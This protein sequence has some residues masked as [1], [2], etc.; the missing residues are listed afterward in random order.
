[1]SIISF[2]SPIIS[3]NSKELTFRAT[4]FFDSY[5][6]F[7]GRKY[8]VISK[9]A[10]NR[11]QVEETHISSSRLLNLF[12]VATMITGFIPLI[13]LI[14]KLAAR[15]RNQFYL[16]SS[17]SISS[18][19][20][21]SKSNKGASKRKISSHLPAK[22]EKV[23]E[24]ARAFGVY[25]RAAQERLGAGRIQQ[26]N[27]DFTLSEAQRA[28][29]A[30]ARQHFYDFRQPPGMKI[31]RGGTHL[32]CQIDSVP[33]F[34]FKVSP[35]DVD[36]DHYDQYVQRSQEARE[37]IMRESLFLLDVPASQVIEVDGHRM[38]MQ[39]RAQIEQGSFE[40]QR[41]L[42]QALLADNDL[43]PYMKELYRQ[44]AVFIATYE[45]SDVKYDNIPISE[46]GRISLIDLDRHGAI[47]GLFTGC[48]MS[49]NGLFHYLP[50]E[51][52][53]EI[54]EEVLELIPEGS[55]QR[56]EEKY[57]AAV[58]E[59][60]RRANEGQAFHGFLAEHQIVAATQGV[61]PKV[62]DQIEDR[63]SRLFAKAVIKQIN[64]ALEADD[65]YSARTGRKVTLE[66]NVRDALTEKA[67]KILLSKRKVYSYR[68]GDDSFIKGLLP[69]V[70]AELQR[71]GAIFTFTINTNYHRVEILC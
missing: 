5:F 41:G 45:F 28:E 30:E 1:M 47:A 57:A 48:A 24:R 10:K 25:K 53:E 51:W 62:A 65:A 12:K 43:K 71:I 35:A 55:R 56:F 9:Q 21:A 59:V 17:G 16:D 2:S 38:I 42:H 7:S 66:I 40:F 32:V 23:R 29:L 69:N 27:P 8:R 63:V 70:M 36:E 60:R 18:A 19:P 49:I 52:M 33:G 39:E 61:N 3:G 4:A 22:A 11:Y 54:K 34:V 6:S 68:T 15:S 44:L 58:I 37:L 46:D 64:G 20:R 31:T 13:M 26:S 14:G 67:K 50:E